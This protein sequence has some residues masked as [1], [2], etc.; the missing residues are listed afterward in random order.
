MHL[1]IDN[2][3]LKALIQKVAPAVA[4][5]AT[6][7]HHLCIKVAAAG[8]YITLTATDGSIILQSSEECEVK[9]PGVIG[10]SGRAFQD[11]VA[12]FLAG[13]MVL[14]TTETRLQLANKRAV[15]HINMISADSFAPDPEYQMQEYVGV[16]GFFDVVDKVRFAT[17]EDD[18][19]L[20][21]SGVYIDKNCLVATDGR[22]LAMSAHKYNLSHAVTVKA[23]MLA[24][25]NKPLGDKVGVTTDG[26]NLH[27][28]SGSTYASVRLLDVRYPNY[29]ALIPNTPHREARIN[30]AD[31]KAALN[32]IQ[33]AA[34]QKEFGAD[35]EFDGGKLT[36]HSQSDGAEAKQVIDVAFDGKVL[37]G[38]NV[39]YVLDVMSRLV[40]QDE[41]VF[42]IRDGLTPLIIKEDGYVNI[43]M[44]KRARKVSQ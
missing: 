24:K 38:V 12:N 7:S 40:N 19:R 32:L 8:K 26:T 3:K 35:L 29:I 28:K 5:K 33:V 15:V 39:K 25:I 44:P 20:F 14:R 17:I 37:I 4:T 36:I 13:P 23:D 27:F 43:I 18:N 9:E 11:T 2:D 41:V 30:F 16:E 22:R 6:L 21:T 31:L 34:E 42:E 1:I 10:I